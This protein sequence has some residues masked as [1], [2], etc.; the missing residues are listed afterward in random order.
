MKK[1]RLF[2]RTTTAFFLAMLALALLAAIT[3]AQGPTLTI[4]KSSILAIDADSSGDVTPG[5]TLEY[6]VVVT[7][8]TGAAVS[9]L[10]FSDVLDDNTA[11]VAGSLNISPLAS[12]YSYNAVGNTP[13]YVGGGTPSEV[14]AYVPNETLLDGAVDA[15]GDTL[16][17]NTDETEVATA[18]GKVTIYN[19]GRFVYVPDTGY[20]G[21]DSFTYTIRDRITAGQGLT[22]TATVTL[23]VSMPVW[24]VDDSAPAGGTGTARSPLTDPNAADDLASAGHT[25]Y[26]YS[27]SY[28][29]VNLTLKDNQSLIGQGK[30]LTVGSYDLIAADT[31][32]SLVSTSGS[33]LT[34]ANSNT[35][36]SLNM[37]ASGT[38]AVSASG[39]SGTTTFNTVN[40]VTSGAA[41]GVQLANQSGS[42]TFSSGSI[43]GSSSGYAVDVSGG[44]TFG[45]DATPV[46]KTSGGAVKADSLTGTLTFDAASPVTLTG[47]TVAGVTAE[48][49][50]G[51]LTFNGGL[52]ASTSAT[53]LNVTGAVSGTRQVTIANPVGNPSLLSSSAAAAISASN[54]TLN[55]ALSTLTSTN[56]ATYGMSLVDT[57]GTLTAT[58]GSITNPTLNAVNLSG[59]AG[60]VSFG[61]SISDN[62]G[63]NPLVNVANKTGGTVSLSG[64]LSRTGGNG[65]SFQNNSGSTRADLTG[66]G[67]TFSSSSFDAIEMAGN[68]NLTL[69]NISGGGL[70][71]TTTSG[72]GITGS[73]GGTISI[74]GS[75]NTI[76]TGGGTALALSNVSIANPGITLKSVTTTNAS[77]AISLNNT[78]AAYGL[79]ITGDGTNARNAS[80]GTIT[81]G[82]GPAVNLVKANIISLRQMKFTG[83]STGGNTGICDGSDNAGCNAVIKMSEVSNISL[84]YLDIQNSSSTAIN[85]AQV[86]TSFSL[87]NS[88]L[89]NNGDAAHEDGLDLRNYAGTVT[90]SGNT[91]SGSLARNVYL[92][93]DRDNAATPTITIS[94]N[95]FDSPNAASPDRSGDGVVIDL[96]NTGTAVNANV[97]LTNNTF[98]DHYFSAFELNNNG[99]GTVSLVTLPGVNTLNNNGYAFKLGLGAAATGTL[100][101]SIKGCSI[102]N[103]Y[104]TAINLANN[105]ATPAGRF[106]GAVENNTISTNTGDSAVNTIWLV[107]ET[108]GTNTVK[109]ANNNVSN[110]NNIGISLE[111]R[112]ASILSATVS[113]NTVNTPLAS[114]LYGVYLVAG[115]SSGSESA[116]VCGDFSSNTVTA[117]PN[118]APA[119]RVRKYGPTTTYQ[120][121]GLSVPTNITTTV[122][123]MLS[124]RN[125]AILADS[126]GVSISGGEFTPGTCTEPVMDFLASASLESGAQVAVAPALPTIRVST[127][128]DLASLSWSAPAVLGPDAALAAMPPAT[129]ETAALSTGIARAA[130]PRAAV[131][132]RLVP[133]EWLRGLLAP[134]ADT[135]SEALP[136]LPTGKSVTL[137]F[138]VT[139]NDTLS[140]GVTEITNQAQVTGDAPLAES[141]SNLLQIPFHA[142]P[143]FELSKSDGDVDVEPGDDVVYTLTF[144][145]IGNQNATGVTIVELIPA[146]TSADPAKNTGWTCDTTH[147]SYSVPDAQI[148]A[149]GAEQSVTFTLTLPA[150]AAHGMESISNS[151]TID[152]GPG[153]GAPVTASKT[154]TVTAAPAFTLTKDDA[155]DDFLPGETITYTLQYGN[156]GNQ[157]AVNVVVEETVP[158]HTT[159]E[160]TG[161]AAWSCPDGG[162]AGTTCSFN[163]GALA[164]GGG[165]SLDFNVVVDSDLTN[166]ST[167]DNQA[168]ID[169]G[170]G[171]GAKVTATDSTSI[172][173]APPTFTNL[174]TVPANSSENAGPVN[175]T[176]H[177]SDLDDDALDVTV[178][179]GDGST[180]DTQTVAAGDSDPAGSLDF[181]HT[182]VDDPA[183]VLDQYIITVTLFDGYA[184]VTEQATVTVT[185]TA[186][187]LAPLSLSSTSIFEG[188]STTISGSFSDPGTA[189]SHTVTINWGDGNIETTP[190]IAAGI[191]AFGPVNHT[192]AQNGSYT[193]RVTVKDKDDGVSNETTSTVTVKNAAPAVVSSSYNPAPVEEGGKVTVEATFTDPGMEDV[194]T[195]TIDWGDGSADTVLT[196][197]EGERTFSAQHTYVQDNDQAPWFWINYEIADDG[198]ARAFGLFT[199]MSVTNV[200]PVITGLAATDTVENSATKLSGEFTDPGT[201]DG[202]TVN[203]DW[204]DGSPV[205][206]VSLTPVGVRAF[207]DISHV[208]AQH[209]SYTI[210][211]TVTDDDGT[212]DPVTRTVIVSN[213]APVMDPLTLASSTILENGTASLSGSFTDPG[214]V[215]THSLTIDWGDGSAVQTVDLAAGVLTFSGVPHTYLQDKATPYTISVTVSD[216]ATT[217]TPATIDLTVTNDQPEIEGLSL[218]EASIDENGSTTLSGSFNDDGTLDEHTVSID[219]GDG[220]AVQTVTLTPVGVRAFSDISHVYAQHQSY[221]ISVT[222]RD[223]EHTSS[224]ATITIT[225]NNIAPVMVD[226]LALSPS[227]IDEGGSTSL[228]GSF[229]DPGTLDEH[230]VKIDWGDGETETVDLA[231]GILTFSGVPH[232]YLDNGTYTI[233]VSVSDDAVIFSA[234]VTTS[235]TVSNVAPEIGPLNLAPDSILEGGSTLLSGSFNDAGGMDTL[236]AT[237]DW[238]DGNTETVT[239]GGS[240][241]YNFGNSHIY[242]QDGIYTITFTVSDADGGENSATTTITV[243]NA[244]PVLNPE[245]MSFNPATINEGDEAKLTVNFSDLGLDD[246]HTVTIDWGDSTSDTTLNL[247]AGVLSFE[248]AHTF[249][250]SGN[251]TITVTVVDEDG[252]SSGAKTIALQVA[253]IAPTINSFTATPTSGPEGT[254]V[255][256]NLE[257]SDIGKENSQ[258]IHIDWGNG[259]QSSEIVD[260]DDLV[261]TAYPY[262]KETLY[263]DNGVFTIT[264]TITDFDGGSVTQTVGPITI[265]NVN[266]SL[267]DVSITS[268]VDENG[269][270]TLSATIIDPGVADNFTIRI[271]WGDGSPV[272]DFEYQPSQRTFSEHHRYLDDN[273]TATPFDSYNVTLSITDKDGGNGSAGTTVVVNNAAPIA[274]AGPDANA[275]TTVPF[276]FAGSFTDPGT[277]DTHTYSWVINDGVSDIATITDSLT[278]EYTF[279]QEGVYTATLTVTDDDTGTDSDTVTI[280]VTLAADLALTKTASVTNAL[281]GTNFRY[282]LSVKNNGPSPAVGVVITDTL[283]TSLAY[284]SGDAGCSAVGQEVTC[285]VGDL[286]V[287]ESATR[288]FN[289]QV[290][291]Y[292]AAPVVNAASVTSD[293][294]DPNMDNNTAAATVTIQRDIPVYDDDF[295]GPTVPPEW[296]G[297]ASGIAV[298][299]NQARSFLG[300][301]GNEKVCLSLDNL[302]D[303]D[304]VRISFDLYIIRSWDG[305]Y[306]YANQLPT[307]LQALMEDEIIGPDEWMLAAGG[308]ELIHTTFSNWISPE[309]SQSY[310]GVYPHDDYPSR[311]G[312][313]E[314]S[315]LGYLF[316]PFEHDTVYHIT[317]V[318]NHS[319]AALLLEFSAKGLQGIKDES[320]GLDN[321]KV[322]VF[323]RQGQYYN[324]L[325]VMRR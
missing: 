151:A 78:G 324:Y 122:A 236:T 244:A 194:H 299:P 231:A 258:T 45:F 261:Y 115:R 208:Y 15:Q 140:A 1:I 163:I 228:S 176:V 200:K 80:G 252:A 179:W 114:A 11:L 137:V 180:S 320:W 243:N 65:I 25:I 112:G 282:T 155:S 52:S 101:F 289:V 41:T 97:T 51:N 248:Q 301:F 62:N 120:V 211:V 174:P 247:P 187:T 167:I 290:T 165:A 281:T 35:V 125:P 259:T 38:A 91:I 117:P 257:F 266:P 21:T 297:C 147:C 102:S 92:R 14:A 37:T 153:F 57:G 144:R 159:Y 325:P 87:T 166:V 219:W 107:S 234:A 230:T 309:F 303:H 233:S 161:S 66:S 79:T 142:A 217:S 220:S 205:Q 23:N 315:T 164:G 33:L 229:T 43:T 59:G 317:R 192:F 77:T 269:L 135:V 32:P 69:L 139:V 295:V 250:F 270:A 81:G 22:S 70:T 86:N 280:T 306:T 314:S 264:V 109:V 100:N 116:N 29:G 321:V 49:L 150:S 196:L 186:P 256:V 300:E 251:F 74:A 17:I 316:G 12:D 113:G 241:P 154:T 183:N 173:N 312:A 319:D 5:D 307:A 60:S 185:N 262:E 124:A 61:G 47:G 141:S 16:Y 215:T 260:S 121:E 75:N 170:A 273:P 13:L 292:S 283:P 275:F 24:Y 198:G 76:T 227:T 162:A 68:T 274:N 89:D 223:E 202:H 190:V 95:T 128:V 118:L 184:T 285:T 30:K 34:L 210:S 322:S 127:P 145:N 48:S 64:S 152:D 207:N 138:R 9:G 311:T 240:A 19:T 178:D 255:K 276:T 201:L 106:N 130:R 156:S 294:L 126:I 146:N 63:T 4:V 323:T 245:N 218:T 55:A 85:G 265:N 203:I 310:P 226:D 204:G 308:Q 94:G 249:P 291:A 157:D 10:Q 133:V 169:D 158:N 67:N 216:G 253:N 132:A 72:M 293:T 214:A 268:P 313:A 26:V 108:A 232:T 111:A 267:S 54:V 213:I 288:T 239:Y 189:D 222:V 296:A 96:G 263:N 298:T 27:G 206:N 136:D 181:S 191:G 84:A 129:S 193:V 119:L 98:T 171:E 172:R 221:T 143:I 18:H 277:L 73:G 175:L 103:N 160:P 53:A 302:P 278:P 56:S 71:I 20:S 7:N 279:T 6:T 123:S 99:A 50:Q 272:E 40:I 188:G 104:G 304:Q 237:I 199:R 83:A 82:N 90:L 195:V 305:N 110:Y 149:G 254:S 46:T 2:H 88:F 42:F 44:A 31:A 8:D 197:S 224:E 284:V 235:I 39:K 212:S 36:Q 238:G 58:G 209:Q 286:A 3:L 168:F 287:N 318:I 225:V 182:Y 271:D 93:S 246:T 131:L 242:L 134:S 28:S 148:T 177:F 105:A